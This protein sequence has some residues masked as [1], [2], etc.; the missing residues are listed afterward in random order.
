MIGIRP[1]VL[2]G[3]AEKAENIGATTTTTEIGEILLNRKIERYVLG[4]SE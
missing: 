2:A 3:E 1:A 4:I